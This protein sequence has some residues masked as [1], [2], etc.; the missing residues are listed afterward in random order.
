[1]TKRRGWQHKHNS[2]K[3]T[4]EAV[5]ACLEGMTLVV[6]IRGLFISGF[7][8]AANRLASRT[9]SWLAWTVELWLLWILLDMLPLGLLGRE[10]VLQISASVACLRLLVFRTSA[11]R[12]KIDQ[13]P[14]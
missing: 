2:I 14:S 6:P 13:V 8:M 12:G 3:L 4:Y 10:E 5:N 7:V 11:P 1:M 9:A